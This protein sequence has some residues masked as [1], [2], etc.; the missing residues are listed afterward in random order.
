MAKFGGILGFLPATQREFIGW[1]QKANGISASQLSGEQKR[2]E[3]GKCLDALSEEAYTQYFLKIV[4]IVQKKKEECQLFKNSEEQVDNI[5]SWL[6]RLK[7]MRE[8]VLLVIQERR[9]KYKLSV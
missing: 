2:A 7:G 3:Y 6:P 1:L 8:L 9:K 4:E 5:I